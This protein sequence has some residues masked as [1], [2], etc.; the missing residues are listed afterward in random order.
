MAVANFMTDAYHF[1][2]TEFRMWREVEAQHVALASVVLSTPEEQQC[3][4]VWE[5][6]CAHCDYLADRASELEMKARAAFRS[7]AA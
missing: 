2:P 3:G 4:A 1:V 6:A 7:V 5:A